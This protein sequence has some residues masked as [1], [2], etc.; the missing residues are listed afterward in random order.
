MDLKLYLINPGDEVFAAMNVWPNSPVELKL[1]GA[2]EVT[3]VRLT[4]ELYK[5]NAKC[6]D[7]E[8]Y[9]YG[10]TLWDN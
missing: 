6:N 8:R 9:V 10:G 1:N 5:S 3:H 7:S 4:K 2:S